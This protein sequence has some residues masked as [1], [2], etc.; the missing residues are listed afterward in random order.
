MK[1]AKE[2]P[3]VKPGKRVEGERKENPQGG[4]R[5][6]APNVVKD[7]PTIGVMFVD[8][9]RGGTLAKRL[10]EADDRMAKVSG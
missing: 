7:L 10:Q 3:Y 4:R 2:G 9:T 8:Q 6:T 1:V 5:K